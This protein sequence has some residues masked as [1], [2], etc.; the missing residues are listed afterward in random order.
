MYK[1]GAQ[2]ERLMRTKLQA[3]GYTVVRSAGSRS[4]MDLVAINRTHI[5]LIQCKTSNSLNLARIL[6]GKDIKALI[7][8]RLDVPL[9]KVVK[10][11]L[12]AR[13]KRTIYQ[14]MWTGKRWM[15]ST[16]I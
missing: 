10:R 9:R 8:I 3:V 13:N 1:R 7:R 14:L 6:R 16:I 11:V 4:P 5:L 15:S 2:F 12:F